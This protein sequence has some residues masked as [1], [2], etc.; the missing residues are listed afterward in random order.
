[1]KAKDRLLEHLVLTKPTDNPQTFDR[2]K[3]P[4]KEADTDDDF[5]DA[6]EVTDE[7]KN[8]KEKG[9]SEK[10]AAIYTTIQEKKKKLIQ[11]RMEQ[12]K[13]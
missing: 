10:E 6:V 9:T 3:K 5:S 8:T 4:Q 7:D 12:E 1:M 13:V 2:A 11:D